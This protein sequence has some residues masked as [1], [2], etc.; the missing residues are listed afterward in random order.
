MGKKLSA[1]AAAA[2]VIL[3]VLTVPAFAADNNTETLTIKGD[4]VSQEVTFTRAELKAMSSEITQKIYSAA[5]NFPT[6]KVMYRQGVPLLYLLEQAGLKDTAQQLKFTSSDGYAR[7]FTY[8]ELFQDQRCY[9]AADGSRQTVPSIIAWADSSKGFNS[10]SDIELALT[11]GQ[12]VKGE[13]NNPWFVKYLETIEVST[14]APGQWPQ[15]TLSQ[16]AGPDGITVKLDHSDFDAVKIY[17][18]LDGTNPDINS[19]LYNVSA[20]YYQPHLNQPIVVKTDTEIRAIAI[21][22]GKSDSTVASTRG[23]SDKAVFSDLGDYPWAQMAIEDLSAR[24]IISG[25]GNSCFAP[26]Q[27]LTRA[28]FATM[29]ILALGEKPAQSTP[30]SFSDVKPADW[31]YGYVAR[32]TQMGLIKGY[33]DNTFGPNQ[34]LSRQEMLA[35]VVQAMGIKPAADVPA[36]L[37]KP[38]AQESRISDWGRAYVAYAESL[39]ILEHGHMARETTT[40]LSLDALGQTNRAEAAVT[41]YRMVQSKQSPSPG[42]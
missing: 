22:A 27:S 34:V 32:A 26:E 40:G 6:E 35:I 11:M 13:Q 20:S 10:M 14:A 23:A 42:K 17:Y 7:S 38:F 5:N 4:G 39:G 36:E 16:S 8:K 12:R 19:H 37:L 25:M 15:V 28:Q 9:F 2:V 31:H 21:G 3:L 41:V 29:I 30:V 1:L 33:P 18:T 24:G